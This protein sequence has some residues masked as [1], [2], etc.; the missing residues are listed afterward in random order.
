MNWGVAGLA[1]AAAYVAL[2]VALGEHAQ[3]RLIAGTIG[4]L[5]PPFAPIIVMVS[6]R[7]AWHG[8]QSVFWAA[9]VAWPVLWLVGQL[10]WSYDELVR[11]VPLPWFRWHIILQLCGSALPLIALVAWPHRGA[12]DENALTT[13]VDIAVLVF[14]TG[15]LYWCLIIA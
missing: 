11:A 7:G 12:R 5:I 15:F 9:V 6:R 1:Y 10:G 4:L 3:A 14:L 8:R 13:A 2:V